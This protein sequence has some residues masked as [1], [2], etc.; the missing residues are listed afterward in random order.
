[1]KQVLNTTSANYYFYHHVYNNNY[2][3]L[4]KFICQIAEFENLGTPGTHTKCHTHVVEIFHK[5]VSTDFHTRNHALFSFKSRQ[6]RAKSIQQQSDESMHRHHLRCI[7]RWWVTVVVGLFLLIK[8]PTALQVWQ[9][10]TGYLKSHVQRKDINTQRSSGG[11]VARSCRCDNRRI[12]VG[13][14][15][16]SF[17]FFCFG[18]STSTSAFVIVSFLTDRIWNFVDS[19]GRFWRLRSIECHQLWNVFRLGL[20][21]RPVG[22]PAW[23]RCATDSLR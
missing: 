9:E 21:L 16:V 23:C 5:R 4:A 15:G 14:L 17:G 1:M 11:D 10:Y 3:F 12:G 8:N 22:L 13:K 6:V 7:R 18:C 19:W 2:C 20:Q